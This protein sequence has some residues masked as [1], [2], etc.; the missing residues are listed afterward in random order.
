MD[1]LSAR[2]FGLLIA[3]VIPGF[4]I[5]LGLSGPWESARIWLVGS[6][7]SGPNLGAVLYVLMA[8]IGLGMTA[9]AIRWSVLD[10]LHE[11]TGVRRPELD[12]SK[13]SDNL[14]AFDYLVEKHFRYYQFYGNSVVA[15]VGAYAMWR[16]GGGV[17]PVLTGAVES[18]LLIIIVVFTAGSRD[19]LR[20]YYAGGL[21]LLGPITKESDDDER[22]AR[23]R[24]EEPDGQAS[25]DGGG[26]QVNE[27]RNSPTGSEAGE[28]V[29]SP[30]ATHR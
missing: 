11:R 24:D 21:L 27:R 16:L 15:L 19:A 7:A 28:E 13:L 29:T 22:K 9:S 26:D 8:S 20:R 23:S 17:S 1:A 18:V 25:R 4:I 6:A 30:D 10:S 5:L 12:E 14:Q 2:N 3:Y